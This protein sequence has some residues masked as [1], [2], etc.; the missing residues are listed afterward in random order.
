MRRLSLI[1]FP[2]VRILGWWR[3]RRHA[4]GG[5]EIRYSLR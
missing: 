2:H 5:L 3:P 1:V 4:P